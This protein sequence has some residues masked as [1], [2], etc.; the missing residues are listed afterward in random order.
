MRKL[1]FTV[2]CVCECNNIIGPQN[3]N[4]ITLERRSTTPPRLIVRETMI[5]V[6]DAIIWFHRKNHTAVGTCIVNIRIVV[7]GWSADWDMVVE[8]SEMGQSWRD[9]DNPNLNWWREAVWKEK[10]RQWIQKIQNKQGIN[11][12]SPKAW[13]ITDVEGESKTLYTWM[14]ESPSSSPYIVKNLL[15]NFD[16]GCGNDDEEKKDRIFR[17]NLPSCWRLVWVCV[18]IILKIRAKRT[19]CDWESCLKVQIFRAA[20][21]FNKRSLIQPVHCI[22]HWGHHWREKEREG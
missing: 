3:W 4:G 15:I 1:S 17:Q 2:L 6:D 12:L 16:N 14:P 19:R 7:E 13:T 18:C 8:G 5:V 10:K 22:Q 21:S 20:M 9:H 11:L